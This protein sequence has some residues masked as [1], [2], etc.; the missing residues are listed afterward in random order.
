MKSGAWMRWTLF[1]GVLSGGC[2]VAPP[3]TSYAL[4]T[5]CSRA[6]CMRKVTMEPIYER[7]ITHL[8][9]YPRRPSEQRFI[10]A[11]YRYP[12]KSADS[13][14]SW[15]R[16]GGSGPTPHEWCRTYAYRKVTSAAVYG[17]R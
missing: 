5:A 1:L 16:M 11:E 7:C 9:N 3:Q 15:L 8:V 14:H 13:Y 17:L 12:L 10:D 4:T 2:A 6:E